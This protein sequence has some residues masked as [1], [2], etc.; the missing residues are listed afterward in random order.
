MPQVAEQANAKSTILS[1]KPCVLDG[2]IITLKFECQKCESDQY[3]VVAVFATEQVQLQWVI[4]KCK[5]CGQVDSPRIDEVPRV[6]WSYVAYTRIPCIACGCNLMWRNLV[7]SGVD[8]GEYRVE[9][10]CDKCG[11]VQ[12]PEVVDDV[13]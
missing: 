12:T 2:R 6:N 5:A 8:D 7:P 11:L 13:D 4:Y 10:R 9:H 3:E 1:T